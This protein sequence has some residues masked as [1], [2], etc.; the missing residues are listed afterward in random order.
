MNKPRQFSKTNKNYN[1]NPFQKKTLPGIPQ[2]NVIDLRKTKLGKQEFDI[3]EKEDQKNI[4]LDKLISSPEPKESFW[5]SWQKK[6]EIRKKEKQAQALLKARERIKQK[7]IIAE[8]IKTAPIKKIE[9]KKI[10]VKKTIAPLASTKIKNVRNVKR[11]SFGQASRFRLSLKPLLLFTICCFVL[12]LPFASSAVYQRISNLKSS[13][14]SLS[15]DAI[16]NIKIGSQLASEFNFKEATVQFDD[17]VTKFSE[18]QKEIDSLN[19]TILEIIPGK[20]QEFKSAK[21]LV[22]AAN[23]LSSAA[24]DLTKAFDVM[25]K[26][27]LNLLDAV[28]ENNPPK[29]TDIILLGYSSLQPA[30]EKIEQATLTLNE[31]NPDKLPVDYQENVK[32]LKAEL[33]KINSSLKQVLSLSE[34]MLM[35]LGHEQSKRY[36]VVFQNNREIRATGGFL[37]SFGLIDIDKGKVTKMSVPTGGTYDLNGNLKAQVVSPEPLHLVNATWQI[38]DANWWP[39]WPTS[40]QKIEWFYNQSD[41]PTVDGVLALTPDVIEEMLAVTGPID[42]TESYGVVID[43]DNFYDI[44]QK[45]AEKKYDETRESKKIIAD[46]T[47]KLLDSLFS[48]KGDST[49]SVLKIFYNALREKDILFYFNDPS[50]EEEMVNLGW[51]GSIKDTDRDYLS[52]VNTNIGGGKTDSLIEEIINHECTIADDGSITDKVTVTRTHKG[53]GE[54]AFANV[55]NWDYV[56]AYVPE[57]SQLI[58][59]EGFRQPDVKNFFAAPENYE[60]D[61]DLKNIS[62]D[63]YLEENSKTRINKE[64]NKTVFGNWI[65]VDPGQSVSYSLTYQ[66]PFKLNLKGFMH[67]TDTYSLLVQKQP[68]SFDSLFNTKLILPANVKVK[69]R[70]PDDFNNSYDT[71]LKTDKYLG[72]VLEK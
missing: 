9:P 70:Y 56:R 57:G 61:K 31:V 63:T 13:V 65:A 46:L 48:L 29:L 52:I 24:S 50:L 23:Y 3:L 18:A 2:D 55:T 41:G 22:T 17:A 5:Q 6:R 36:L 35:I 11:V 26:V 37:G 19:S 25:S 59:A 71:T 44:I 33:P 20:G 64:F 49:L 10:V 51:S 60:T 66:L 14:L 67:N 15:T 68:G 8:K 47:P 45:E 7:A 34:T 69:W 32:T 38:Q 40:A 12:I 58:T 21:N 4:T 72:V 54:E 27:D 39:D 42:M 1:L 53:S 30:S 28:D 16:D 62:G 43:K